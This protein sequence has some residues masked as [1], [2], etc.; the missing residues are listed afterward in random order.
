MSRGIAS[1]CLAGLAFVGCAT[2]PEFESRVAFGSAR[3]DDL[4]L[5]VQLAQTG[6]ELAPRICELLHVEPA[7]FVI[8]HVPD[9]PAA[10]FLV[11]RGPTGQILSRRIDIGD[12]GARRQMRFLIG[13]ELVHWYARGVWDRLPHAVEEGLADELGLRFSED[14]RLLRGTELAVALASV[15][16]ERRARVL[17]VN[18]R[19]WKSASAELRFDAYAVGFEMVQRIGVDGLRALCERAED[20]GLERVPVAWLGA[21]QPEGASDAWKLRLELPPAS[22]QASRR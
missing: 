16:P 10:E 5:A 8:W 9:V 13:H 22:V 4:E 14:L 1:L 19:S 20:E 17:A 18:E 15:T 12:V 2:P 6:N 7:P 3:S 11:E 21:P